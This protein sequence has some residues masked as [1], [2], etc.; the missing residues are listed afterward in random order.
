MELPCVTCSVHKP[1]EAFSKRQWKRRLANDGGR[2][3]ACCDEVGNQHAQ[4]SPEELWRRFELAESDGALDGGAHRRGRVKLR[5]ARP[6]AG[7][8][9]QA[10]IAYQELLLTGKP[11]P[12]ASHRAD[13][14]DQSESEV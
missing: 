9:A 2:C 4:P 5:A 7:A 3:K 1:E 12:L 14:S 10:K 13:T 11:P 8:E 6:S